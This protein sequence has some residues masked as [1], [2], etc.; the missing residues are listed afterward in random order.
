MA[1]SYARYPF[2][3]H[4]LAKDNA[5]RALEECRRIAK[6][7]RDRT[8]SFEW[9]GNDDGLR[10]LIH[11]SSLGE[12]DLANNFWKSSNLLKREFGIVVSIQGPEAGWIEVPGGLK[13]FF[14]PGAGSSKRPSSSKSAY[15]V[16]L[17]ENKVA[18]P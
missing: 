17:S 12:W 14:V 8:R 5:E 16:G 10:Q 9:L 2:L 7:R 3:G 4:E 6:Y 15:S 1:T 18:A 13:A 11:Q